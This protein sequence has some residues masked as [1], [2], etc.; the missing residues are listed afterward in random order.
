MVLVGHCNLKDC[1]ITGNTA[2][3]TDTDTSSTFAAYLLDIRLPPPQQRHRVQLQLSAPADLTAHYLPTRFIVIAIY[4]G[5]SH[6]KGKNR[7]LQ[8]DSNVCCRARLESPDEMNVCNRSEN[9]GQ[10]VLA[11]ARLGPVMRTQRIT[12]FI[13]LTPHGLDWS[14]ILA[15][16]VTSFSSSKRLHHG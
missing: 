7:L 14:A 8:R 13:D 15:G 4:Q 3:H 11:E 1:E 9:G 2:A 10:P 5:N 6:G 12:G 16:L